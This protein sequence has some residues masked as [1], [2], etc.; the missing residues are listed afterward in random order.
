MKKI[1]ITGFEPFGGE[2]I[3]PALVAVNKLDGKIVHGCEIVT[4]TLPVVWQKSI[5]ALRQ[6]IDE[7]NPIVVITVGQ[8]GGRPDIT[9]ERVAVNIDDYRIPDNEGN[10]P[11]DEPIVA[12]GPV[13]Y[14]STL[15][16]KNAV[17]DMRAKGIPASV[18][19]TAGTFVCNHLFYGLMHHLNASANFCRGGFVHIPYLPEQA[20]NHPG[21]PSMSLDT[22]VAALAIIV[23]TAVKFRTDAKVTGGTIC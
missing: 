11:I 23:E 5:Q 16:L 8:A 4:R 22:I 15:P 21:A 12:G 3:N 18:S 6:A 10:Q 1:L 9:I 19:N 14:L 17:I 20:A 13:G 7:V 2:L